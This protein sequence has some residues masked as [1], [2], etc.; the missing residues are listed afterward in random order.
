[1]A[2]TFITGIPRSGK[3]Y[4][5][6]YLIWK[7]YRFELEP[8]GLIKQW[9]RYFFP[10]PPKKVYTFTY[11]NINEFNFD[12]HPQIRPL[13]FNELYKKLNTLYRLY[14]KD[15]TDS[16]LVQKAK[17]L[18]LYDS[19]FVIDEVHNFFGSKDDEVIT[20]WLTYHGHLHQ[21]IHLITQKMDLVPK[22]YKD[23]AEFF[24]KAY[25]SSNQVSSKNFRYSLHTS[26]AYHQKDSKTNI[27][28]PFQKEVFTLYK[29]GKA[30]ERVNKLKKFYIIVP[31]LLLFLVIFV[32]WF[33]SSLSPDSNLQ[34]STDPLIENFDS[35][36][37]NITNNQ[38]NDIQIENNIAIDRDIY[39]FS[40]YCIND[41]CTYDNVSFPISF[42]QFYFK[43]NKP[44]YYDMTLISKNYVNYSILT[45]KKFNDLIVFNFKKRKKEDEKV[46][47]I[48][49]LIK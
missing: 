31:L 26:S 5:S 40:F 25:P 9:Y 17:E 32:V 21:E 8:I 33:L 10:L 14:M 24:Y 11:T 19:Y 35:K 38:V 36:S 1:M 41:V 34:E 39:L 37:E 12:Y 28:I 30:Q 7:M 16:V 42:I 22:K 15:S 45:S 43:N 18:E 29:S 47:P 46:N 3:T 49:T 27:F 48:N 44:L 6:V 2:I 4:R 13:V 20:W 23:I